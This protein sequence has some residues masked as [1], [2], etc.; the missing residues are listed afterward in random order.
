MQPVDTPVLMGVGAS[1]TFF[2]KVNGPW[3]VQWYKN[4]EAIPGATPGAM[5]GGAAPG[6]GAVINH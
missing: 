6:G 2:T 3:P 5:P 1:A 4:G